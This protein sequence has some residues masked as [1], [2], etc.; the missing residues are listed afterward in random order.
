LLKYSY[1]VT[2]KIRVKTQLNGWTN[3][4]V[5][6]EFDKLKTNEAIQIYKFSLKKDLNSNEFLDGG[7]FA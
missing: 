5:N 3:I 6:Q 4:K 1:G 7:Y 2:V